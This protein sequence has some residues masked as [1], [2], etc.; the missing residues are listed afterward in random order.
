MRTAVRIISVSLL[1]RVG[2]EGEE[3]GE[4]QSGSRVF[5]VVHFFPLEES[6]LYVSL[7]HGRG[8][9]EED[10]S[11]LDWSRGI[12]QAIGQDLLPAVESKCCLFLLLSMFFCS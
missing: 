8:Y 3:D 5:E 10:R 6:S 4:V 2:E 9:G 11:W 7:S 12:E 1:S